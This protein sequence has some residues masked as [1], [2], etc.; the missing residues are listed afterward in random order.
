MS[1]FKIGDRVVIKETG[2]IKTVKNLDDSSVPNYYDDEQLVLMPKMMQLAEAMGTTLTYNNKFYWQ[3]KMAMADRIDRLTGDKQAAVNDLFDFFTPFSINPIR[4]QVIIQSVVDTLLYRQTRPIPVT[5]FFNTRMRSG[6]ELDEAFFWLISFLMFF[7]KEYFGE[8]FI[9]HH[10]NRLFTR[11]LDQT[12]LTIKQD[13][14]TPPS[15]GTYTGTI[16]KN[17]TAEI[18]YF[19]KITNFGTGGRKELIKNKYSFN[20]DGNLFDTDLINLRGVICELH[21]NKS[22]FEQYS[23]ERVNGL[24]GKYCRD[25]Q[26]LLLEK[27]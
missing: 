20:S 22:G 8:H 24:M 1:K 10:L 14:S 18:F 3:C 27:D 6:E 17:N 19:Q 12:N 26:I 4:D 16:F 7:K 5:P 25:I 9:E 21:I 11:N 15:S 23:I 13:L 2:E